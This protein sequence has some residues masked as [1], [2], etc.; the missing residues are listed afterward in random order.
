MEYSSQIDWIEGTS[1]TTYPPSTNLFPPLP[2]GTIAA[3]SHGQRYP[4]PPKS[5]SPLSVY[6][7]PPTTPD[8]PSQSYPILTSPASI[9]GGTNA[10]L[11]ILICH[12]WRLTT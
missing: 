6:I 4:L 5:S 12:G 1:K 9:A 7:A 3:P 8:T 11:C 10:A 2:T